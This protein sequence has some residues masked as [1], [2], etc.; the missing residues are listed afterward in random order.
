MIEKKNKKMSK[1]QGVTIDVVLW[2]SV[3][4]RR[5]SFRKC[6]GCLERRLTS[7]STMCEVTNRQTDPRYPFKLSESLN[8]G[9]MSRFSKN[10]Q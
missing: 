4:M 7:F 2:R 1:I 3:E 5:L 6:A 10:L 8:G 9:H